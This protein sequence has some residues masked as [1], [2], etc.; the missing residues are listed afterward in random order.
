MTT[1]E[2]RGERSESREDSMLQ[3]QLV[4]ATNKIRVDV[5]LKYAI[6]KVKRSL[7][8]EF[9]SIF[10]RSRDWKKKGKIEEVKRDV[11]HFFTVRSSL[12]VPEDVYDRHWYVFIKLILST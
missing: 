8:K 4:P 9:N 12:R 7:K 11:K 2:I 1:V 3:N 5:F 10:A 6:R